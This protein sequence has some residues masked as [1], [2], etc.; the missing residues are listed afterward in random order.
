MKK[1]FC[2]KKLSN[3]HYS[4]QLSLTRT[5]SN[6]PKEIMPLIQ[7]AMTMTSDSFGPFAQYLCH[8]EFW[9]TEI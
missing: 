3:E 8:E 1:S 5:F 6:N 2:R 7:N 4:L 9:K